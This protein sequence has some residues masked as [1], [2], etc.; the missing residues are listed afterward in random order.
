ML[1]LVYFSLPCAG[2]DVGVRRFLLLSAMLIVL[3]PLLFVLKCSDQR[4]NSAT[5]VVSAVVVI[6]V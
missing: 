2:V 4:I 5:V 1:D 6:E 3:F